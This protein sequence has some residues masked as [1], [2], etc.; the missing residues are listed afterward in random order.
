M[1]TNLLLC[2]Q[3]CLYTNQEHQAVCSRRYVREWLGSMVCAHIVEITEEGE[4]KFWLPKHRH[5]VLVGH[6]LL[7]MTHFMWVLP[8]C[9]SVFQTISECFKEDGPLGK[10]M[11]QTCHLAFTIIW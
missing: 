5:Q 4:E 2:T 6:S 8:M 3:L 1:Y 9:A 7:N 11:I 10:S